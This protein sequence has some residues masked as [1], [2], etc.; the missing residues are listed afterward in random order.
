MGVHPL[1]PTR[2]VTTGLPIDPTSSDLASDFPDV[3]WV[4]LKNFKGMAAVGGKK[5]RLHEDDLPP[6]KVSEIDGQPLL[7]YTFPYGEVRAWIDEETR[8]PVQVQ[9]GEQITA[10]TYGP[11]PGILALPDAYIQQLKLM[12]LGRQGRLR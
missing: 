9:I 11:P 1:D 2:E 4:S 3:D 10:F 5:C 8:L 12:Q 6:R 7:N